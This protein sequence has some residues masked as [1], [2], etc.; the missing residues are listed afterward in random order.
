MKSAASLVAAVPKP[1]LVLAVAG[2]ASVLKL[3]ATFK[4]TVSADSAALPNP[5]AVLA[6]L[7]SPSPLDCCQLV[8]RIL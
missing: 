4:N 3:S 2:L 6:A 5:N 8:K 7:A 1:K